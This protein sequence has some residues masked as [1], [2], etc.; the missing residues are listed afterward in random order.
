[1][2]VLLTGAAGF[3]GST[4]A[5]HLRERGDAVTGIDLMLERAH[6]PG[7]PLPGSVQRVDVRDEHAL[8]PLLDGVDAVCH[9]AAMVGLGQTIHD[10]PDYAAH[11]TLA[12]AALV[13]AMATVGVPLLVQA[14]SMVVYGDGRSVC[15]EHGDVTP[16]PRTAADLERGR[17]DP[18]CPT[19]GGPLA[20]GLVSE[21]ARLDPRNA[22]AATKLSQEHLATAWAEQ[23]GGCA[24]SLRYHNVYGPGMP[25]DTP[26]AGVASIFRS[27]VAAGQAP[28]VY[29]DGRQMR[30]FIH[31]SD[32]AHAN[33]LALT[34]TAVTAGHTAYNV[35]SGDP[36][37]VGEVAVELARAAGTPAPTIVGGGRPGDVRHVVADPAKIRSAL[38]F[39]AR[40]GF[41]EGMRE[42]AA[43][44]QRA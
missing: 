22:Y 19:C 17:F 39:R 29:E 3:I 23:A 2:R 15:A 18:S 9:Q 33:V 20:W 40:I 31:V 12:T 21:D 35:A 30:D 4:I 27:A 6:Q 37:T 8:L 16:L 5:S 42:F 38:G 10:A 43:A 11:N 28:R 1:M 44:P 7:T 32:V 36:H 14:S 34:A 24:V 26:Y 25:R 41:T 13:S